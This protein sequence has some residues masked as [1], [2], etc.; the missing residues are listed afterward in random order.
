MCRSVTIGCTGWEALQ[1]ELSAAWRVPGVRHI[2]N[3]LVVNTVRSVRSLRNLSC[4]IGSAEF[5]CA[6]SIVPEGNRATTRAGRSTT[7]ELPPPPPVP[8]AKEELS[9]YTYGEE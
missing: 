3:D 8:R 6:A 5:S 7:R 9:E 2:A 4:D 1:A